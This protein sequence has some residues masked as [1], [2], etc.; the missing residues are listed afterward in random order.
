MKFTGFDLFDST[1]QRTNSWLKELMTELNWSDHRKTYLAFRCVLHAL[2]DHLP[3]NEA[4]HFGERLPLLIRGFYFDH[5]NPAG[6]PLVFRTRIEFLSALSDCLARDG[7][8]AVDGEVLARAVFR[9]LDRKVTEG[10]IDDVRHLFPAAVLE[11]W[12][13][14]LRAA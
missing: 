2:R 11:L 13:P 4:I 5:W 14:S 3:M 10:E 6:K 7:Q 12:P 9:L 1:I 8:S